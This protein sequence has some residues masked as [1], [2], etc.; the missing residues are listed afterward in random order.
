MFDK[1]VLA[2]TEGPPIEQI[3]HPRL[4]CDDREMNVVVFLDR[5][6]KGSDQ[7]SPLLFCL[8]VFIFLYDY[9]SP[10]RIL[11]EYLK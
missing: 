5:W 7:L 4:T 10:S 9:L 8:S 2:A 1:S 3:R 11:Y 6:F